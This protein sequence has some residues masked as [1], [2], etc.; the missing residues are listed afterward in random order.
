MKTTLLKL[1]PSRC[2]ISKMTGSNKISA[3]QFAAESQEL[4]IPL[5]ESL[6][7]FSVLPLDDKELSRLIYEPTS[8]I[9]PKLLEI[10]PKLRL[11]LVPYLDM[12][13]FSDSDTPE[14][15]ISYQAPP[16][17]SKRVAE[18][19][20]NG[21]ETYLFLAIRDESVFDAHVLFYRQLAVRLIQQTA[22][23]LKP[24]YKLLNTELKNK[25]SGEV[26]EQ[27]WQIKQ[28]LLG[29][30]EN[31]SRNKKLLQGY[32]EKALE[33]TLTIYLHGLCCDIDIES[34]PKQ[35]SN[36]HLRKRLLLLKESLPPP[37][38]LALFPEDIAGTS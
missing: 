25:A 16:D 6:A 7:Y 5:T 35:L 24:F 23:L 17:D 33:D 4:M 14:L 3:S 8:A 27:S 20:E 28:E 31:A 19:L 30:Q 10:I 38:G 26:D 21:E 15:M 32:Q 37:K 36:I 22:D 11:V 29:T 2:D 18:F 12:V 34:G 9:P 13:P 1:K